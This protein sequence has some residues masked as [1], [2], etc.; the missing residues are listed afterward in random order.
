MD[1]SQ[2]QAIGGYPRLRLLKVT[3]KITQ[4]LGYTRLRLLKVT[5]GLGYRRLRLLKETSL[6]G[7]DK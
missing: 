4:G 1:E 5:Q 2:V 7:E 6:G 3:L